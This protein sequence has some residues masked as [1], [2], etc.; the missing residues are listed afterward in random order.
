MLNAQI[1]ARAQAL[2]QPADDV[3]EEWLDAAATVAD[4]A[5]TA[6]QD[7]LNTDGFMSYFEQARR[8]R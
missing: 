7:L 6:Y 5:R 3:P 8:S 2:D 4:A 1:R